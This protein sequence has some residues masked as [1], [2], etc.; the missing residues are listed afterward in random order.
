MFE[1]ILVVLM[2]V[3]PDTT[4][5]KII[6]QKVEIIL[7]DTDESKN[8]IH[9][10]ATQLKKIKKERIWVDSGCVKIFGN[11]WCLVPINITVGP[12]KVVRSFFIGEK[13]NENWKFIDEPNYRDIVSKNS[14]Y[15]SDNIKIFVE[16]HFFSY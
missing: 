5:E 1:L 6:V 16:K 10:E 2:Q 8:L 4:T 9:P 11:D 13:I 15:I 7:R 3:R 14:Y 12:K